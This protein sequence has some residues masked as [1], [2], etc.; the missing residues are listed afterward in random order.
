MNDSVDDYLDRLDKLIGRDDELSFGAKDKIVEI[1]D[2]LN[3]RRARGSIN[4]LV[5]AVHKLCKVLENIDGFREY[6]TIEELSG[7]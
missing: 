1:C 2:M 4:D 7:K 5:I 6:L 3:I